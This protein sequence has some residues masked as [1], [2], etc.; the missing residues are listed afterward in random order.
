MRLTAAERETIINTNAEDD[1]AYIYSAEAKVWRH[2]QRLGVKP[3][4]EHKDNDSEVYAREYEVP[5]CW[6]KLPRPPKQM[7]YTPEQR[8]EIAKRLKRARGG[9]TN[10][11]SAC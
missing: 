10:L 6:A 9:S 11:D 5:K 2:F 8:L 4:A 1:V 7:K 3:T